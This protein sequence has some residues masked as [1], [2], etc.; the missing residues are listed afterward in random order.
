MLTRYPEGRWLALYTRISRWSNGNAAQGTIVHGSPLAY[1]R[2]SSWQEDSD[3]KP[4]TTFRIQYTCRVTT[5]NAMVVLCVYT[6]TALSLVDRE[7]ADPHRDATGLCIAPEMPKPASHAGNLRVVIVR[8]ILLSF[9][10]QSRTGT[11]TTPASAWIGHDSCVR[12]TE[13]KEPS[14]PRTNA[15]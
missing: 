13:F 6:P 11:N 4:E 14:S 12:D 10:A 3:S 5:H 9:P 8:G 1:L 7:R 15:G 2:L